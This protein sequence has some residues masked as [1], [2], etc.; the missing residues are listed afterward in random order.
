MS[1]F[2]QFQRPHGGNLGANF[3]K[4]MASR[5]RMRCPLNGE[6][7]GLG[8]RI[9]PLHQ[10]VDHNDRSEQIVWGFDVAIHQEVVERF[11]R[12]GFTGFRTNSAHVTFADGSTSDEYREFIVTGWG[13]VAP[14]ES[15]V[16]L[17]ENCLGCGRRTYSAITNFDRVSDRSQWSDED[18]FIVFP[19][20]T[21]YRFCTE[22]AEK[23]LRASDIKSFSISIPFEAEKRWPFKM[24]AGFLRGPISEALPMELVLKYGK[25]LG[26]G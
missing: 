25:S 14:P 24:D 15:G 22:R 23:W 19:F 16:H 9:G 12:E 4:E 5:G 10:F 13:G 3:G 1:A 11:E 26:L 7:R 2:F 21:P 18:F 8:A 6:H 17:V 20:G